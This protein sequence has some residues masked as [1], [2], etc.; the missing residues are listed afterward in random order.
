LT[1]KKPQLVVVGLDGA[2]WDVLTPLIQQGKLPAIGRIVEQGRSGA[3][4]SVIPPI[5]GPAWATILT[6]CNPGEH[7]IFEMTVFDERLGRRRPISVQDWKASPL[8]EQLNSRGLS[9]GLLCVPFTF[10]PPR[11]NG[12]IISGIMGTPRYT[13]RMFSPPALHDEVTGIAGEFPLAAPVRHE[14]RFP[15]DVLQGQIDWIHRASV[16]LLEHHPVDVFMVVENFTDHVCHFFLQSRT[17]DHAGERIDLI[18]HVYRAC[19]SL[20]AAIR[21]RVGEDTPILVLS[22]HG[23]TPLK[24]HLNLGVALAEESAGEIKRVSAVRALWRVARRVLP[25]DLSERIRRPMKRARPTL[26]VG[27]VGGYGSIFTAVADVGDVEKRL[28]EIRDPDS[29]QP[30]IEFHRAEELYHGRAMAQAPVAVALPAEGWQTKLADPRDGALLTGPKWVGEHEGTHAL[31]G[32][33]LSAGF[34]EDSPLPTNL[35]GVLGYVLRQ[36]VGEGRSR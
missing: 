11:V 17:H 18:E 6:G 16:H 8:W 25:F 23:F 22:D 13:P 35:D 28:A 34:A 4:R 3:L 9:T 31:D 19:D 27:G 1:G 24:G 32:V 5:T 36:C 2:T 10:P 14:G 15:M 29:G 30:L 20:I 21:E 7:G 33:V 12:W 26:H